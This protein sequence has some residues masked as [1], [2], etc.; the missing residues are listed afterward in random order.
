MNL[1]NT[2]PNLSINQYNAKQT[3]TKTKHKVSSKI[4]CQTQNGTRYAIIHKN[5]VP[6]LETGLIIPFSFLESQIP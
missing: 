1:L 6:S 4:K 3:Q 5:H 2:P